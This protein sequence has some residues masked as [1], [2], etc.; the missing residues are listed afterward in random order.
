MR[1]LAFILLIIISMLVLF[2]CQE[3]NALAPDFT[4]GD[5]GENSLAPDF[6]Q[7]DQGVSFLAKKPAAN[8]IGAVE[9]LFTFTPP[10]FW[11]G[12]VNFGEAGICGITFIS[13]EGTESGR[14]SHFEED[15]IIYELGNPTNIYLK[16]WDAGVMIVTNNYPYE[17]S[18]A[19]G[20]GRI[21]EAYGPFEG[22]QG[23]TAHFHGLVYWTT[24]GDPEKV[25][26]KLRIN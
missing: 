25:E 20:N 8:L 12:T 2:S 6:N 26:I 4:Q 24:L 17:P 7:D 3:E 1:N 9:A 10:T 15:F 13:K 23:C 21:E 14:T 5:Q 18:K 22:W 16:G 19:L 11:N